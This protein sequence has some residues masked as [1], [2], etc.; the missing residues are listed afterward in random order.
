MINSTNNYTQEYKKWLDY[1][2]LD[3]Q[4]KAELQEISNNEAMIK[5]W[6]HAPLIFGTAGLRGI[7]RPG[8]NSMNIY[9]V[10]HATQGF[11]NLIKRENGQEQGVVI[12]YDSRNNSRRFAEEAAAT[13]AA[14]GIRVYL[15]DDIRPTP[16]LSFAIRYLN[17]IAGI[18]ITASHNPK[19]YNGYKAY[20]SDGAQLPLECA[21]TVLDE[22][23][24][25]DIFADVRTSNVGRD[26]LG[27]PRYT[28][29]VPPL[30]TDMRVGTPT[31]CRDDRPRSSADFQTNVGDMPRTTEAVV[32]TNGIGEITLIGK[33][34]DN[35]YLD[36]V[37]AQ[38][39]RP[40]I[41]DRAKKLAPLKI[42]YTPLHGAGYKLIPEILKRCGITDLLTVPP[43][44]EINGDFPT[45]IFPNPEFREVFELGIELAKQQDC[46]LIIATDPDADR[47]GIVVRTSTGEYITISGN[48]TGALL[49]D[50][51]IMARKESG[52]LPPNACAIKTI[53]ST[54]LVNKICG[55]N[56]VAL[57]EV[58]TGFKFIGEKIKQWEQS[59]EYEYIFGFEE[60]YGYLPG[61]YARDK[62]AVATSM[63][64][65]EMAAYYQI[66]GKTLC[67][68]LDG[69]YAKYGYFAEV[70]ENIEFPGVYGTAKMQTLMNNLRRDIPETMGDY[71]VIAFRDYKSGEVKDLKTRAI[72]STGLP[73]SDV[74]Y[75]D[76][77]NGTKVIIR[78]SGTEPKIKIYY[79]IDAP[80]EQCANEQATALKKSMAALIEAES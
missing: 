13:L 27:T 43:Q 50:Y 47:T 3:S 60:S 21:Q 8:I 5:E 10:R 17:C 64:I 28:L 18:N 75:Y 38:S 68:A 34:V 74:L 9:T 76:L 4:T 66:Q 14:N 23:N 39:V 7:M 59:G 49:L 78:P 67:D 56:N 11:A 31:L 63:M 48:Q 32:P 16:E 35:A 55:M 71:P 69:L 37:E 77:A 70:G 30:S 72:T 15:F 6:F 22:I 19:E 40:D 33:D 58:L 45:V 53:V 2:G 24:K 52:R 73:S 42:M 61:T 29:D 51:I 41:I 46:N 26:A 1:E 65:S 80:N 57:T 25:T 79:L 20:W 44:M 12:A 62:D 36:A 54:M